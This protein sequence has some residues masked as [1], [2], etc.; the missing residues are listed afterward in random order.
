M[1]NI[2]ETV[3]EGGYGEEIEETEAEM[4]NT[5]EESEETKAEEEDHEEEYDEKEYIREATDIGAW[6]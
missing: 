4:E 2:I 5:Y 3:Q 1:E 6:Q